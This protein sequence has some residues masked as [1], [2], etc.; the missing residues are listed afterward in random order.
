MPDLHVD[1][2]RH[3][4]QPE[5]ADRPPARRQLGEAVARQD[6]ADRAD[7]AGDAD[8][9]GEELE[10]QQRE[11]DEEQQ[12]RDGRAGHRVEQLVDQ[13]ELREAGGGDGLALHGAG[14]GDPLDRGVEHHPV[15]LVA[16]E[17]LE[18]VADGGDALVGDALLEHGEVAGLAEVGGA[19]AQLVEAGPERV[20]V[21]DGRADVAHPRPG[22]HAGDVGDGEDLRRRAVQAGAAGARPTRR[23]ARATRRSGRAAP[24]ITASLTTAP[25][26]S[27]WSTS[28][29]LFCSAAR[30]I[31]SP[32]DSTTMSSNSPFTCS[33][34]TGSTCGTASVPSTGAS[35]VSPVPLSPWADTGAAAPSRAM[36]ATRPISSL[37]T[38][39]LRR[40]SVDV[41]APDRAG[42]HE[43]VRHGARDRRRQRGRREDHGNGC[44]RPRGNAPRVG[45]CWWS[46]STASAALDD[47]V[48]DVEVRHIA[49]ATALE[50]Y[51]HEH[52]F[53]RIAK[54]LAS[55]GVIDVVGTAAP[56]IDDLVVLGKIKQLERSGDWDLIVVD[57]PAAGHAIT[58]LT[59]AAGLRDAVRSGPVRSQAD[60][61]L[62][63][64]RR[65]RPLPGGARDAARVDPGQRADRDRVLGGGARRRAARPDRGEPGRRRR[66]SARSRHRVVR[67]G[68]R[69]GRRR[70]RRGPVPARAD[71][72][73]RPTR[74]RGSRPRSRCRGSCCR[75]GRSPGSPPTTSTRSRWRSD[76]ACDVAGRVDGRRASTARRWWC[77]AD[78]AASARPR[79]RR[80]WRW[81][82][83]AAAA[84]SWW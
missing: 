1:G 49:P 51:L 42:R 43:R 66:R 37:R 26:E 13:A 76:D 32:I 63:D 61:V 46:S 41:P 67:P 33:T 69:P 23:S 77:A 81:R 54:R 45:A 6:R 12:V 35:P 72:A 64:A 71:A 40:S 47:L 2:E 30:S 20:A 73:R 84:A 5:Q 70:D 74:W 3:H 11:T 50:E 15:L 52:G 83:R 31:A 38:Q 62:D 28:A 59:S 36:P 39:C 16:V 80:C 56:G 68:P 19:V 24:A 17:R 9:G 57:G 18:H 60:E 7:D 65:P 78:R 82:P 21:G 10:D 8:A 34:S 75:D 14:V 53:K 55:T 44:S 48:P 27:I 4:R 79:W 29:W 25:R 58:F 22:R